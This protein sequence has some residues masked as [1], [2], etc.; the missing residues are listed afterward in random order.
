M[1]RHSRFGEERV[2]A[3][4]LFEGAPGLTEVLDPWLVRQGSPGLNYGGVIGALGEA[5]GKASL[6]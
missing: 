2:D 6:G 5:T 1:G 4:S 3:P